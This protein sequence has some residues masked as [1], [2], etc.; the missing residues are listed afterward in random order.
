[1]AYNYHYTYLCAPSSE[2]RGRRATHDRGCLR[3]QVMSVHEEIVG[4]HRPQAS[5]CKY[6]GKR[7]RLNQGLVQE[8]YDLDDAYL[9]AGEYN[10]QFDDENDALGTDDDVSKPVSKPVSKQIVN[11]E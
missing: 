3:M 8:W 5:P 1:M 9:H 4:S 7:N 10:R 11:G 6:C 2:T